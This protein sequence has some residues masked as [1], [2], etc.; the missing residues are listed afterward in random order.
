M[1]FNCQLT[2]KHRLEF[3][4]FSELLNNEGF[5]NFFSYH[6]SPV[7]LWQMPQKAAVTGLSSFIFARGQRMPLSIPF[8]KRI[9]KSLFPFVQHCTLVKLASVMLSCQKNITFIIKLTIMKKAEPIFIIHPE[10][11]FHD[12]FNLNKA[13]NQGSG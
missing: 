6:K 8:A 13:F 5:C 10:K 1:I 2:V 9:I 4:M 12:R 11:L 3:L 7:Y